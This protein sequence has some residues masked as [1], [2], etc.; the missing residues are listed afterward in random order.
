MLG[1]PKKVAEEPLEVERKAGADLLDLE[2]KMAAVIDRNMAEMERKLAEERREKEKLIKK[3][4]KARL[5]SVAQRK[6]ISRLLLQLPDGQHTQIVE[7]Y[8]RAHRAA[9]L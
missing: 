4:D 2:R 5:K 1:W 7:H 9:N 6:E 8:Q 3:F